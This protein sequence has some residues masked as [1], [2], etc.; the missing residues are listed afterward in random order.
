MTVKE[1]LHKVLDEMP[2][3]RLKA[4]LDFA[5]FLGWQEERDEHRHFAMSQLAKAYGDN[6]P[7]YMLSDLKT[8]NTP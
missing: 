5:E 8:R 1:S 7:E 2:E 3:E 6:E 4:V